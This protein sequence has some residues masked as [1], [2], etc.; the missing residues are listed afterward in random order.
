VSYPVAAVLDTATGWRRV[1]V[2]ADLN[3]PASMIGLW[4]RGDWWERGGAVALPAKPLRLFH[5]PDQRASCR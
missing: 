4:V 3:G 1:A 5:R 2:T